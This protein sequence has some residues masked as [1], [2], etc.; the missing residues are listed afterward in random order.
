MKIRRISEFQRQFRFSNFDTDYE[1]LLTSFYQTDLGKIYQAIPW[2]SLTKRLKIKDNVKGPQ[3]IF[4]PRGKLGLMFLK[5]YSACSD[6]RLIEQLNGNIH[7]QIFCDIVIDSRQSITNY[8]L[9]SQ[10]RCEL[11]ELLNIED[12]QEVLA[13]SWRPYL[14]NKG[15]ICCDATCYES[16]IRY[17]TDI[18][19]LWEAVVWNYKWYIKWCKNLKKRRMRSKYNKWMYR[20]YRYS[21]SRRPSRKEKR[22]I[23]RGLLNLLVKIDKA[24]L[25]L[26]KQ[27]NIEH[28]SSYVSRRN[29]TY[30]ILKQQTTK[31]YEGENPRAR[32]I[33]MDKPYLRPILRGKET[34]PVEFGAKVHKL[35]VDGIGF[36]EH[37]SFDA[38]NEST[39]LQST[40]YLAQKLMHTRVK[41]LGADA[42]YATNKNRVYVSSRNIKTDFKR[43][44]RPSKHKD[45]FAQL[46]K[47]ITKERASRLEGSFGT[48]KEH[49]LLN[50]IKARTKKTEILWIFFGIH[51][52]NA[53]NIGK[54][55][56]KSSSLAA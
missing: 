38:F 43:K 49:F 9:V 46:S 36:I 35:Q 37:L 17:P 51:T 22:A 29:T 55:L 3:S 11:A 42:I 48:D 32:I 31:F 39:R 50:H 6:K 13:E 16:D 52:A 40:I 44:G 53:L 12:A 56:S 28:T 4:S 10:I 25:E 27:L 30:Q 15:S 33:S 1:N 2:Q 41:I 18:K 54:R 34:K 20:Y 45:Q 24:M 5:H 26:D 21:K 47:M 23:I 7:Y 19:L 8:K 14:N